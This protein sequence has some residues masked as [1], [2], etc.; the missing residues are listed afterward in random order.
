MPGSRP[1][2]GNCR[3][4]RWQRT[5]SQKWPGSGLAVVWQWPKL[6]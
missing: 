3:V 4:H 1:Q 5:L 6:R 2:E